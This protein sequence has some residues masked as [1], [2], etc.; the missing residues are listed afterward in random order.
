MA[1]KVKI[2]TDASFDRTSGAATYAYWIDTEQHAYKGSG[3]FRQ[4][5]DNSSVAELLAFEKAYRRAQKELGEETLLD[6]HLTTDSLWVVEGLRGNF[7]SFSDIRPRH[8]VLLTAVSH[9]TSEHYLT[10]KHIRAHTG[11]RSTP[12]LINQWCDRQA[13]KL[14][15][16]ELGKT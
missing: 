6:I 2:Y 9:A 7:L 15:R 5:L 16:E 1:H 14:L 4:K 13:N 10:A 11:K 3:V 8:A 12:Y